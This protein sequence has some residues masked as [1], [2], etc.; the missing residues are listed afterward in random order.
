M[1]HIFL[2]IMLVCSTR[3]RVSEY[4]KIE[5]GLK[6][7]KIVR[8]TTSALASQNTQEIGSPMRDFFG[9]LW[10]NFVDFIYY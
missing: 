9:K 5:E 8:A 2:Y 10:G 3:T 6:I 4:K 7:V 1:K